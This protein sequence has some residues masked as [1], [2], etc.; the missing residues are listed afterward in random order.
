MGQRPMLI[1]MVLHENILPWAAMCVFPVDKTLKG[2]ETRK[3]AEFT[4]YN[5]DIM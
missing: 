2:P 3:I 5:M 4:L 1:V